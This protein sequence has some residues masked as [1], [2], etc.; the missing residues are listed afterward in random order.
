MPD[1]TI[2]VIGIMPEPWTTAFCGVET[3]IMNPNGKQVR[4]SGTVP[5]TKCSTTPSSVPLLANA[6]R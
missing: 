4:Y 2:L 1:R 5:E 6:A 3:G